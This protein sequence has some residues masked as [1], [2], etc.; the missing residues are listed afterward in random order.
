[1]ATIAVIG[2]GQLGSRH[3]QALASLKMPVKIQ[4]LDSSAEALQVARSRFEEVSSTFKGE[5][6]YH[7]ELKE[8]ASQIDVAI[9]ATGSKVRRT[10]I[11]QI[12]GHSKVS[13]FILEKFLFT[14]EEDYKAIASLLQQKSIKAWVNCPRRMM[15]LYKGIQQEIKGPIHFTAT[16]NNWGL[17]CNGIHMLDLFSF[18]SGSR[19]VK[20]SGDLIDRKL[21]ESKR[22]GYIEFSGSVQGSAGGSSF[23]ITSFDEKVSGLQVIIN[24][25]TAKYSISEPAGKMWEARQEN[26]WEWKEI[27]F[28]LPFQSQLTHIVVQD[29]L[30]KGSCD[31]TS[32]EVSAALHLSYLNT[33]LEV[34]REIKNDSSIT[35][36]PVT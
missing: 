8:L 31:L 10:L 27:D 33:L 25:A 5:I 15:D 3:L 23:L 18:L 13:S 19:D 9:V 6:S 30:E 16:G 2:A 35:E 24:T 29:I 4:V 34:L 22:A 7:T 14:K 28:R 32:Y 26:N 21:Q 20:I 11:E 12:C 36:C 17:G 1:M